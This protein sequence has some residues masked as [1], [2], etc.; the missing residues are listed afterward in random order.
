V[1]EDARPFDLDPADLRITV[2]SHGDAVEI[3]GCPAP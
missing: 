2:V 1:P 3:D